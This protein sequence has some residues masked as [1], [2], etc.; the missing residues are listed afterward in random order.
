M[1]ELLSQLEQS[2]SPLASVPS[3]P[4]S[5][6]VLI[7]RRRQTLEKRE[8]PG[9]K[10]HVRVDWGRRLV[11]MARNFLDIR[12]FDSPFLADCGGEE[13]DDGLLN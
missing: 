4:R 5:V 1:V 13:Q 8:R 10:H 6:R 3:L 7:M 12:L 11:G 9:R 2:G